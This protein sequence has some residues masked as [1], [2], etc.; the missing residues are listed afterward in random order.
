MFDEA[1]QCR[2]KTL[3]VPCIGTGAYRVPL[4]KAARTALMAVREELVKSDKLKMI[5]LCTYTTENHGIY[6]ELM[7]EFFPKM[8][9]THDD[10]SDEESEED[11]EEEFMDI[12][13]HVSDNENGSDNEE[14]DSSEEDEVVQPRRAQRE[15]RRPA[16]YGDF[17]DH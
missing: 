9:A 17:I 7:S 16:W 8:N 15:R 5:V 14:V 13:M 4:K 12:N 3:A 11:I 10:S 6:E 2:L 1:R